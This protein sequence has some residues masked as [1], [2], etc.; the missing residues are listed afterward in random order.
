MTNY[1]HPETLG[2]RTLNI[3]L[4]ASWP[5]EIGI[6]SDYD[7]GDDDEN[8]NYFL[9]RSRR[10]LPMTTRSENPIVRAQSMGLRKPKAARGMPAAL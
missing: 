4:E 10:A 8:E 9:R 7:Y 3:E 1:H 6:R 5:R 2:H